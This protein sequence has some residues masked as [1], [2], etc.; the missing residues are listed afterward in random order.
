MGWPVGA[1]AG[2][3]AKRADAARAGR[4]DDDVIDDFDI[5]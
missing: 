4:G 5:E 1:I 3:G 2:H